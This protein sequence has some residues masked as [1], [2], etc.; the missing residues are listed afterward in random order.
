LGN[1]NTENRAT[2]LLKKKL[3]TCTMENPKFKSCIDACLA[4]AVECNSCA[5][6]CLHENDIKMMVNCIQLDRQCAVICLASA[7]LMSIGGVHATHLCAECAEICEACAE[8]CGR[9]LNDHCKKCA[10]ACLKCAREC[11]NM[12]TVAA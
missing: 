2:A 1:S 5:T 4:C 9:H 12:S 3:N 6:D 10:E 7:Q 8:E 11:R